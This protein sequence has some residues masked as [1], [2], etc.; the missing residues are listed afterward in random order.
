MKK[1][2][3]TATLCLATFFSNAS[4]IEG[5]NYLSD[6]AKKFWTNIDLG[7]DV[8]RLDWADTLGT[9][10]QKSLSDYNAF[11]T[12]N[13]W[14]FATWQEFTR[15][16]QWFDTDPIKNGWS[17]AQ[18]SGANLFFSL[19]GYGPAFTSQQGFDHE[20]YTYW[21]FGTKN[22]SANSPSDSPMT[23]VWFADFGD[24]NPNV[25]CVSWS[26]LCRAA[27]FPDANTPM[28]ND[29]NSLGKGSINVAPL[30][31]RTIEPDVVTDIPEPSTLVLLLTSLMASLVCLRKR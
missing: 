11:T 26:V 28:W 9:G 31:V 12:Q 16:Y 1:A 19:N 20:G 14:R 17:E 13:G 6:P 15:L 5:V 27:Y 21:Q 3:L 24:Q 22:P 8:L 10:Q 30:L 18:N 25:T 4:V 29:N 7:L 23:Y 2:F